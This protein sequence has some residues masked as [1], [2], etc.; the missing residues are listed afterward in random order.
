MSSVHKEVTCVSILAGDWIHTPLINVLFLS[1][2]I[3]LPIVRL[4]CL[5]PCSV[6]SYC[7]SILAA[8]PYRLFIIIAAAVPFYLFGYHMALTISFTLS[9]TS[10]RP[11]PR[12]HIALYRSGYL[13]IPSCP[14]CLSHTQVSGLLRC[15]QPPDRWL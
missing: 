7:R 8:D 12:A 13:N 14:G 9:Y 10:V 5:E 4:D 15:G 11:G 2:F 3:I 6:H 1:F